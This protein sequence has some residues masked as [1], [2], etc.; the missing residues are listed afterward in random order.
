MQAADEL[1]AFQA[2]LLKL[3]AEDLSAETLSRR[4]REDAAYAGFREYVDGFEPRMLAVAAELVKKWGK[5]S[6]EDGKNLE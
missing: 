5:R 2:A 3:L 4:L 6:G 1:A